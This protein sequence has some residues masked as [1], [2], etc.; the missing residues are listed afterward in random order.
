MR[1]LGTLF[2]VLNPFVFVAL[3]LSCPIFEV[4]T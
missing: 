1:R 4:S 2:I 3:T